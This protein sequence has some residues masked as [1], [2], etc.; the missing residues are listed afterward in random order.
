GGSKRGS[1]GGTYCNGA[2]LMRTRSRQLQTCTGRAMV[3]GRRNKAGST[4]PRSWPLANTTFMASR[5]LA[6]FSMSPFDFSFLN[7]NDNEQQQPK[8]RDLGLTAEQVETVLAAKHGICKLMKQEFRAETM[9]GSTPQSCLKALA[10]FEEYGRDTSYTAIAAALEVTNETAKEYM[11]EARVAVRAALGIEIITEGDN[12]RIV[13]A[14]DA[15]ERADRVLKVFNQQVQ[16]A[17]KKLEACALSLAKSNAP[18]QLTP[19]VQA[20]LLAATSEEAA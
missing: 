8:F 13:A 19:K 12:V 4:P 1:G 10:V 6:L 5:R 15:R 14:N 18:V 7:D 17:L 16:P 20:L 3:S 9:R 11:R 2:V